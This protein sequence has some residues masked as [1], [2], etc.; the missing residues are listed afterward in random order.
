[1]PIDTSIILSTYNAEEW[2]E[3]VLWSYTVQSYPNFEIVIADDGSNE[4]TKQL[5]ERFRKITAFK[6]KHVWHPDRGFQKSEIL[7]K[8][9]LACESDYI[10]MSDGDCIARE[11]FVEVHVKYRNHGYFLSGGYF[12]LPMSISKD[13]SKEDIL[14]GRCF[15]LDWLKSKGLKTTFKNSKISAKTW[16]ALLLNKLTPTSPTWNGH[17]ASGWKRDILEVNGFDERMQYGG[18]DRELGERLVNLGIKGKQ[19]RYSAI[20]LHLDHKRGYKNQ[21]SIEKNRAIRKKTRD[22]G[23]TTT[24]FGINKVSTHKS[25]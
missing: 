2:L 6:I 5:I 13:I 4:T 8:A 16:K 24:D 10:I 3:K 15:N 21:E 1:M 18:Q 23:L 25:F 17:N 9:I 11:D 19:I 12:K 20:C 14:T 22:E 7:N